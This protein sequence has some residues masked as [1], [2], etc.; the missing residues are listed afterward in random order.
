MQGS[1]VHRKMPTKLIRPAML[2][3]TETLAKTKRHENGIKVNE[4]R[5]LTWMY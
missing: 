3:G 4:M 2:C 1:I 5:M